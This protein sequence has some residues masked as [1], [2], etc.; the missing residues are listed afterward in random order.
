MLTL[1]K[2]AV[3]GI[4]SSGKSSACNFF[5]EC[6]AYVVSADKIVHQLLFP[7]SSLGKKIINLLGPEIIEN[8]QF[9][10]KKIAHKVFNDELLLRKYE[11]LLHPVVQESIKKEYQ[12]ALLKKTSLFIVEDP[13]LLTPDFYDVIIVINSDKKKCLTRFGNEE[14][15]N[16]RI[17]YQKNIKDKVAS[18]NI[19]IDNNGTKEN[20]RHYVQSIY[21]NLGA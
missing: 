8:H 9:D 13:L 17:K 7:N 12:K 6:G 19:I 5:E 4:L 2:I 20:L 18:A 15:F 11:G 16:K 21:N 14:D 1:R 10:R 3:T